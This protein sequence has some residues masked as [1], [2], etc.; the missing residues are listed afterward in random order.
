MVSSHVAADRFDHLIVGLPSGHEPAL[1]LDDSGHLFLLLVVY[2][3]V[4]G[5]MLA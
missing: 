1:A 3:H 2:A 5:T 4:I